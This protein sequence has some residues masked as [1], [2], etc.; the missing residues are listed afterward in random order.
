[1]KLFKFII[2][3]GDER[4]CSSNANVLISGC[5]AVVRA[6]DESQARALLADAIASDGPSSLPW[7]DIAD[8]IEIDPAIA[9][10][11]LRVQS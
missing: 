11:V 2:P 9:G 1:M 3:L 4:P 7:A 8:M 6:E 10:V 5:A